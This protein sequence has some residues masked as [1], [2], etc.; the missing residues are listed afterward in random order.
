MIAQC[1]GAV[2]FSSLFSLSKN[3]NKD[4]GQKILS[5]F[6]N[7]A[8]GGMILSAFGSVLNPTLT[9]DGK[10]INYKGSYGILEL[11]CFYSCGR[12]GKV[13]QSGALKAVLDSPAKIVQG[14]ALSSLIAATPVQVVLGCFTK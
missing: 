7:V 14:V 2:F 4:V 8:C 3:K 11:E 13:R 5:H 9:C 6:Q 1:S 12:G 10:I